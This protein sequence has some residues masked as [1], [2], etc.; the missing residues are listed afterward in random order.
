MI[1]NFNIFSSWFENLTHQGDFFFVQ[2]IQRR[3]DCNINTNYNVIKNYCFF[4]KEI[5]LK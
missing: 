3:K 1:D 4:D 2:V 5:F